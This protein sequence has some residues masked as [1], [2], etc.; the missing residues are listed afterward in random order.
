VYV[1]SNGWQL[2]SGAVIGDIATL[3]DAL[4]QEDPD[5]KLEPAD[6]LT[7]WLDGVDVRPGDV[8]VLAMPERFDDP[9]WAA[10]ELVIGDPTPRAL[11][12]L[13]LVWLAE[14][15]PKSRD[16]ILLTRHLDPRRLA[17][18]RRG[19]YRSLRG[20]GQPGRPRR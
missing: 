17:A 15:C 12:E 5:L 7:A 2:I 6:V 11:A 19:R 1:T 13:L 20:P 8:A 16:A 4:E 3:L 14:H 18:R 10:P 9:G